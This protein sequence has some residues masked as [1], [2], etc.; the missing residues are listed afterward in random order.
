MKNRRIS[1]TAI[2]VVL[3]G[4]IFLLGFAYI[5]TQSTLIM[6]SSKWKLIKEGQRRSWVVGLLGEPENECVIKGSNCDLGKCCVYGYARP[7][8]CIGSRVLVYLEC[9][10]VFYVFMDEDNRMIEFWWGCS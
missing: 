7:K 10:K 8:K 9:G 1:A 2:L 6:C 3:S 4:F 5:V